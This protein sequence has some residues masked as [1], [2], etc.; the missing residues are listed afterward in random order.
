MKKDEKDR[1]RKG[2]DQLKYGIECLEKYLWCI[3][4][5]I[6]FEFSI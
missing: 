5:F 6:F 4:N 1:K 2:N 3:S